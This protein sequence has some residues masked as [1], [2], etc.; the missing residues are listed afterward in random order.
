MA[1]EK[2]TNVMAILGLIFAFVCSPLGL[3]FSIIAKNQI[4]KTGENGSGLA[5][6]GL[7][8]SIIGIVVWVIFIIMWVVLFATATSVVNDVNNYYDYYNMYNY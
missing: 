8:I 7:V 2:K 6:A 3:V 4:K 5:T 1:V